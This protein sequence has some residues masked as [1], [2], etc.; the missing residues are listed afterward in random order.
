MIHSQ[1]AGGAAEQGGVEGHSQDAADSGCG[2]HIRRRASGSD[3]SAEQVPR[4]RPGAPRG[5]PATA[6]APARAGVTHGADG[7]GRTGRVREDHRAHR[8]ARR[9]HPERTARRVGC[10]WTTGTTTP[11][12]SGPTWSRRS[13]RRWPAV[14]SHALRLLASA[15]P[16]TEPRSPPCS[17]TW[18]DCRAT[19]CWSSTTTTSS[20]QPEVHD[21]MTFLLEHRPPQLHVVLATRTDPPLPLARMRAGGQ[22]LEVRAADLRFTVEESAAYLNGPMDLRLSEDDLA[23]LDGRTEGWIAALQLAALSMQGRDD[24]SGVHRGVRRRRPLRRGLSRRGG[25]RPPARRRPRLPAPDVGARAAHRPAVRRGHGTAP[26]AGRPW[27]RSSA[28]TCSSSRSTTGASGT[29]TTTCSPTC[30]ART[31]S[32]STRTRCPSCTGGRAP[33]SR[34]TATA[35]RRSTTRSPAVTRPGPRISWSSPCR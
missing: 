15:P 30:C 33:G 5:R 17:T 9:P 21:G 22:L 32:T 18:P 19:C 14:G 27:W 34:P 28:P 35:R 7:P 10:R 20:R 26:A 23:A 2:A 3:T 31:C 13:G 16:A 12:C 11:R 1:P 4:P 6:H 8:L 25:A 29:G 24:V